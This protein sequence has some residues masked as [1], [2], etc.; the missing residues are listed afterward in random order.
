MTCCIYL[1]TRIGH[2]EDLSLNT[3]LTKLTTMIALFGLFSRGLNRQ[4]VSK[5]SKT[6]SHI[7]S[8][9]EESSQHVSVNVNVRR[10]RS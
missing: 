2:S 9:H 4:L 6:S 8:S 1:G 5:V 7:L 10:K 3:V